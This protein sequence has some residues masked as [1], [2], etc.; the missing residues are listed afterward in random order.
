MKPIIERRNAQ[1]R[2]TYRRKL[3]LQKKSQDEALTELVREFNVWDLTRDTIRSICTN[4]N[5][6][7][8]FGAK[9]QKMR[10]ARDAKR[11]SKKK[12]R[13][14]R[15][16]Q[17]LERKSSELPESPPQENPHAIGLISEGDAA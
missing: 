16:R 13:E 12:T 9:M 1:I 15:K 10:E 6:G 8:P 5:Y 17:S 3:Q 11:E 14:Q 4:V 7:S 2:E